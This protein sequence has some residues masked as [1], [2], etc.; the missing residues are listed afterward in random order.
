M[1][2]HKFILGIVSVKENGMVDGIKSNSKIQ[3][4]ESCDRPFN[5]VEK[6]I[7]L[8]IKEGTFSRMLFSIR[9]LKQSQKESFIKVSLELDCYYL[10]SSFEIKLRRRLVIFENFFV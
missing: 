4:G 9:R 10:S 3:E 1:L 5:H 2:A 7:I 6:M 8:N